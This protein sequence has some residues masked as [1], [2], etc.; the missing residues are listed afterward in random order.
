MGVFVFI[1]AIICVFCVVVF[2]A[3][4]N[5]E[6]RTETEDKKLKIDVKVAQFDNVPQGLDATIVCLEDSLLITTN[7]YQKK[8]S[9]KNIVDITTESASQILSNPQFS[10]GKAMAGMALIGGV[11]AVAGVAGKNNELKM[12]V[13]SYNDGAE[14]KYMTFLQQHDKGMTVKAEAFLLDKVCK[15]MLER[16]KTK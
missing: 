2:G 4:S 13:L 6:K 10:M 14:L 7:G 8:I 9:H 11:G 16:I 12:I 1:I 15:D 3:N 5:I